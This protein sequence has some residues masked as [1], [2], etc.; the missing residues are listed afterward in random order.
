MGLFIDDDEDDDDD[1]KSSPSRFGVGA[2][3]V[4]HPIAEPVDPATNT[5]NVTTFL[6]LVRDTWLKFDGRQIPNCASG[7]H[8]NVNVTEALGIDEIAVYAPHGSLLPFQTL[9]ASN[10]AFADPLVYV[11]LNV[12]LNSFVL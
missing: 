5:T 2:R 12:T 6:P 7:C 11:A 8:G 10:G 9:N 3:L 4:V 1:G